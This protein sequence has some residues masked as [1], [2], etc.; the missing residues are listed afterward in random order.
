MEQVSL[1]VGSERSE[2]DTYMGNTIEN[3]G[4]LFIYLFIYIYGCT[5]AVTKKFRIP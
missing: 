2:R 4:Y 3:W 1:L 5:V